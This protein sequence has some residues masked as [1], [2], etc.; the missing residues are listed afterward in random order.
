M[1]P[2]LFVEAIRYPSLASTLVWK[3]M[4]FDWYKVRCTARGTKHSSLSSK[5]V[6]RLWQLASPG[7][8]QSA[9]PRYHCRH[10]FLLSTLRF[11]ERLVKPAGAVLGHLLKERIS[12]Y[13]VEGER[14]FG[15]E[16]LRL[17]NES[18]EVNIS[19][20]ALLCRISDSLAFKERFF[21]KTSIGICSRIGFPWSQ[22][23]VFSPWLPFPIHLVPAR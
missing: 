8:K 7:M 11:C 9:A 13:W 10:L 20:E 4:G 1:A 12:T 21:C 22:E 18:S 23:L 5:L 3:H 2:T 14:L 6:I 19:I 15:L 17:L 16:N